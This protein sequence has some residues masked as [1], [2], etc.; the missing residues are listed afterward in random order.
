MKNLI[1]M[2]K[3]TLMAIAL[4]FSSCKD[5]LDVNLDPNNPADA[6]MNLILP[7]GQA[8]IA[9]VIGGEYHNLGGF[10]SQY[11]TQS[12]DAGQWEDIDMY[13][14]SSDK[15]D[16]QWNEL[17]AGGINDL[18]TVRDK[19]TASGDN[20]YYLIAT[21]CQAYSYQVLADL[22][23]KV[24]YS[25]ALQGVTKS[26][27]NPNYDNGADIYAGLL[28]TIDEAVAR[29]QKTPKGEDPGK[30]DL[31]YNGD[32]D[33]WLRFANSLKLKL[34]M[35]MAYTSKADPSAVKALLAANKFIA[36]DAAMTQFGTSINKRNPFY[37]VHSD[38]LGGVNEMAS[39]TMIKLLT[40]NSDPRID[41]YYSQGSTGKWV[42][43]EQGDFTNRDIPYA[44]LAKPKTSPTAPVYLLTVTELNFLVAEARVRYEGGAS[45]QEA[46]ENGIDASFAMHAL[47]SGASMYSPGGVYEYKSTGNVENDVKQIAL[48]KWISLCNTQN[49]EAFFELNRTHIPAYSTNAK[50]TPGGIGE[51]TIS[52]NSVLATGETPRRLLFPDV[53]RAR[54]NK[55]P[56]QPA[57]GLATKIWWDN[58]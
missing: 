40:D 24:P 42:A 5:Y 53:E 33:Q 7:A 9:V 23:D 37:E 34:Y 30:A 54:N 16:D 47:G 26:N 57:K 43:K 22:F 14:V 45:A 29:Y 35:R 28:S 27:V 20:T 6:T 4:L 21:L 15:F 56:G 19:A 36:S 25:E 1:K 2:S 55:F 3:I 13:N 17:Y 39:N 12:P 44:Q 38:R 32:M 48:Q 50:G 51:L 46:Y 18:Q 52:Y 8:S 41:A 10:W 11:Y 31:F 49:L 58:K